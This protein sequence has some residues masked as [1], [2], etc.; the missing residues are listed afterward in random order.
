MISKILDAYWGV[1]EDAPDWTYDAK[2]GRCEDES[3]D[4]GTFGRMKYTNTK[5]TVHDLSKMCEG[6]EQ[7]DLTPT[8][9][10]F[11]RIPDVTPSPAMSLSVIAECMQSDSYDK[12]KADEEAKMIPR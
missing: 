11:G 1:A 7:C 8:T 5:M 10:M 12:S 2:R 6:E 3:F 9:Q 4:H